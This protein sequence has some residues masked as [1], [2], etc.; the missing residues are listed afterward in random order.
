[1]SKTRIEAPLLRGW[2]LRV[3]HRR[4]LGRAIAITAVARPGRPS[5][6]ARYFDGSDHLHLD[7]AGY[8]AMGN[9]VPLELLLDPACS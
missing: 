9:A 2:W 3:Q 6:I 1:M 7:L 5:R 8:V 4:A